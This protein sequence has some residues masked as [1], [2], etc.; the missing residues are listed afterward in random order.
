M[1][2]FDCAKVVYE[3]GTICFNRNNNN[4]CVVLDGERGKEDDR[5]CLVLEFNATNSFSNA[6]PNRALI[7]VGGHLDLPRILR[8]EVA[9][10]YEIR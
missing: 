6:V 8:E 7:P 2:K 3:T 1:S 9:R 4:Y 10:L 5:C